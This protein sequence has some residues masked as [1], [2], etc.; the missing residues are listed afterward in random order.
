MF[1]KIL[2][3]VLCFGFG[4]IR[5]KFDIKLGK[6]KGDSERLLTI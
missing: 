5:C 3:D 2:V 6:D 4:V 1:D